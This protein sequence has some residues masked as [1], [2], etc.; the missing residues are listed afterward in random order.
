M[1]HLLVLITCIGLSHIIFSQKVSDTKG[2]PIGSKAPDFAAFDLDSSLFVLSAK[3]EQRPLVIIFYRGAWCPI[4]NKHL[5][6]IQD[7]LDLIIEAGGLIAAISPEKPEFQKLMANRTNAEFSLLYDEDYDIARKYNVLFEPKKSELLIYNTLLGANLKE[8]HTDGSQRLPIPATYI[9]D[10][11][12]TIIWR[13]FDPNYKNRASVRSII[14]TLESI[15][16]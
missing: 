16:E 1:K 12:Q 11:N 5:S 6:A 9:I 3:S 10:T 4:C 2:L 13:H 8:T 15:K 7:S 14:N